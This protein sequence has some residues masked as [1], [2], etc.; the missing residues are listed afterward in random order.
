MSYLLHS[1]CLVSEER[2]CRC[3]RS[4]LVPSDLKLVLV[5]KNKK[6]YCS[7]SAN[8]LE[9]DLPRESR[10]F[11]VPIKACSGCFITTS[12][13]QIA[14]FEKREPESFELFNIE[15]EEFAEKK[16]AQKLIK[17]SLAREISARLNHVGGKDKNVTLEAIN[18]SK[19]FTTKEKAS[20]KKAKK[21][22]AKVEDF[23]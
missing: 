23:F 2:Q 9:Y 3:G 5:A 20:K 16:S 17:A 10:T 4:Y 7:P 8:V 22:V 15:L 1:L 13:E 12:S 6:V 11:T 14:L 18:G 21:E 19:T